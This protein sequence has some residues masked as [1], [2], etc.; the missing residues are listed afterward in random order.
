MATARTPTVGRLLRRPNGSR[1]RYSPHVVLVPVL[2]L[3][4]DELGVEEDEAA[5]EEQPRVQVGLEATRVSRHLSSHT[6][7][8]WA[9]RYLEEHDGAQE[10]VEEGQEEQ[11]R[12]GRHQGTCTEP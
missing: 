6:G 10:D 1:R 8:T 4:D 2:G 3:F 5:H 12:E 9:E 11:Q 7:A